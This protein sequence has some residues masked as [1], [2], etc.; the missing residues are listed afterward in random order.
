M[1]VEATV[2]G[3]N[4]DIDVGM[5]LCHLGNALGR[6]DDRTPPSFAEFSDCRIHIRRHRSRHQPKLNTPQPIEICAFV[7]ILVRKVVP[8]FARL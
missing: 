5:S 6:A 7:H 8:C 1:L 2:N 4:V 3:G